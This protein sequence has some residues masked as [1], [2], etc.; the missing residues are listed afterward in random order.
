M[1]YLVLGAVIILALAL[2]STVF[3]HLSVAGVKPDLVLIVVIFFSLLNG[4]RAGGILGFCAGLF[5]DLLIGRVIGI[6]ALAKMGTGLLVGLIEKKVY[7]ENVVVPIMVT[8][9][10]SIICQI[11]FL[12]LAQF[13]P[14]NIPFWNGLLYVGIPV[15]IYNACLVPIIYG[16]FYR[17][18]TKGW[19]KQKNTVQ[20]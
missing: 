9:A 20:G 18:S 5:E 17:S 15:A 3:P 2:Q 14:A 7:R 19:L 16:K 6:N 4:S 11:F 12:L 1:R 8:A 10:G 13:V